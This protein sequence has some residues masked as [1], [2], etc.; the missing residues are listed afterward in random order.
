MDY[1]RMTDAAVHQRLEQ[2]RA[3][4]S[5]RLSRIRNDRM[6]RANPLDADF[7]EQAVQRQNDEVLDALE[8]ATAAD[9]AAVQRA[10]KRLAD[11]SY[12]QC[13]QCGEAIEPAR[14]RALPM[15]EHCANCANRGTV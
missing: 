12:G 1:S 4:L 2:Q 11:G 14:L 3:E 7:A 5:D 6:R 9:L 8:S 13:T 10:L 15:A